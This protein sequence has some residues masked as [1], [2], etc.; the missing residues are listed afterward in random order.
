MELSARQRDAL[1]AICD[2]FCPSGDGL[3]S[4]RE[5]GVV[6]AIVAAIGAA[7]SAEQQQ[8]RALLS[9]WDTRMM[10]AIGGGGFNSFSTM[11][12]EDREQVLRSWADSRSSQRRAVFQALRK[13][14]LLFYYIVPG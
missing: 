7:R 8:L 1:E 10:G 14:A 6:E 12:Q 9:A 4:C 3:S 2:T 5:L 11:R 13:A